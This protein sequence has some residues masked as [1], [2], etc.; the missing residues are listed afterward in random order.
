MAPEARRPPTPGGVMEA[1]GI[2][3]GFIGFRGP[4]GFDSGVGG[5][6]GFGC[7]AVEGTATAGAFAPGLGATL[8]AGTLTPCGAP[9]D[10]TEAALTLGLTAGDLPTVTTGLVGGA[11]GGAFAVDLGAVFA[12][13]LLAVC[14][15]GFG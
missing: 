10:T 2:G 14:A 5:A 11:T 12:E 13:G 1:P 9:L 4:E 8:E 15:A 6:V 7:A 3:L